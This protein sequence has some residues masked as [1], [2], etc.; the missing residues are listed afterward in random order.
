MTVWKYYDLQKW[1]NNGCCD[2]VAKD[3][4]E[5]NCSYNQL[6]TLPS[7]IGQLINLRELWCVGNQLTTLPSEIGQLINLRVLSCFENQL[8][9]L[10]SEIYQLINLESLFICINK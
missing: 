6:T 9:R 1:I 2:N 4:V 5:L 7:E 10:P 8:T 3:V